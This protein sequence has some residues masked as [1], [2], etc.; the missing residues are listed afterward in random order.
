VDVISRKRGNEEKEST[1]SPG[2]ES[3]LIIIKLME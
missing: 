1:D 2:Y 3:H